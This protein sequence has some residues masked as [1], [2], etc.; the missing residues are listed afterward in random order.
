MLDALQGIWYKEYETQTRAGG[1]G[2]RTG[3]KIYHADL[4]VHAV[5]IEFA[6]A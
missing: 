5:E 1:T 2:R 6:S 3:D 4:K